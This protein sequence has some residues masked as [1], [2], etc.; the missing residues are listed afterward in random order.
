MLDRVV[1]EADDAIV[2]GVEEV[3][4]DRE[5]AGIRDRL[6]ARDVVA[7][8]EDGAV[9]ADVQSRLGPRLH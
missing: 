2:G 8:S 7:G 3:V 6:Q 5:A 4:V 1:V 9:A